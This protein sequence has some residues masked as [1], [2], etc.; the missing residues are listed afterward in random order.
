[1]IA[2]GRCGKVRREVA[3]W[4]GDLGRR[5]STQRAKTLF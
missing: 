1:M 5:A 3:L 4:R 2:V